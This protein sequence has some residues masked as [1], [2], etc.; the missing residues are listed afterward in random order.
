MELELRC[1]VSGIGAEFQNDDD[2]DDDCTCRPENDVGCEGNTTGGN[3]SLKKRRVAIVYCPSNLLRT[4]CMKNCVI[5]K[6][7]HSKCQIFGSRT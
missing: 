5:A 4:L 6:L 7:M 2:D 1:S 3:S